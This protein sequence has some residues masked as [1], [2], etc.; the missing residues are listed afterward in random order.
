MEKRQ[1]ALVTEAGNGMGKTFATI[2]QN[3][4][5]E[6]ILGAKGKSHQ[7][8]EKT[9]LHGIKLLKMDLTDQ[10]SVDR[11][12]QYIENAHGKLDVLI[13]NAEI[14]NGFGQKINELKIEEI[15]EL[16]EE[17]FFSVIR[18]IQGLHGLLS[19]SENA[20]IVNVSSSLGEIEK[21]KDE[22]F[23][24]AD[25]QMT[26]YSTAKAALE[27]LTLLLSKELKPT[28]ISIHNFNPIR[29]KNCT[30]NSVVICKGVEE[31]LL[32]L[33]ANNTLQY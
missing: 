2:L 11:L 21:M 23:C 8:L 4:G 13:N 24:Y 25:Y 33:I 12:S 10:Q 19:K 20:I 16:F 32:Q 14:A 27:M 30:H 17:N 18:T 15:K 3:Q 28:S 1:I 6:V 5:Y 7:E 26:G 29:L 9:D 22:E 31:E